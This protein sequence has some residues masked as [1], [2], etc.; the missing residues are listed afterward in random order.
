MPQRRHHPKEAKEEVSYR[1]PKEPI[2]SPLPPKKQN[3][4]RASPTVE[5][6][7]LLMKPAPVQIGKPSFEIA[8]TPG[9]TCLLL[10]TRLRSAPRLAPA[11]SIRP[12]HHDSPRATRVWG[13]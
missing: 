10:F 4:C 9:M 2:E 7:Y 3:S 12:A 11:S 6:H 8:T 13:V 1:A 5:P